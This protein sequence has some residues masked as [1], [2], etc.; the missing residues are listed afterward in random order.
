MTVLDP[1]TVEQQAYITRYLLDQLTAPLAG[2]AVLRGVLPTRDALRIVT[3]T[4]GVVGVHDLTA[5]EIPLSDDEGEPVTAPTVLGWTRTLVTGPPPAP[6]GSVMGMPLIR[7]DP[8]TLEPAAPT[9]TDRTLRVLRTLSEPYVETPPAPALCGFLITDRDALRLYVAVEE[10]GGFV[11]ADVRLTG[12]VTALL[13]ALPSLVTEEE[14]WGADEAD[15]HC[16][17][18]VD[19]T[20]W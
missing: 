20:D 6:A 1:D 15:P 11:A 8:T 17:Y 19:L 7:A 18:V 10:A 2:H 12:A 13:A 9:T 5:Y 16:A 4:A 14:R 3:G